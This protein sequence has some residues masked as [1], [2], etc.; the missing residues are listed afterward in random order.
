MAQLAAGRL[1][2]DREWSAVEEI[3]GGALGRLGE[4]LKDRPVNIQLPDT[5]PLLHVDAVL[6]QQVLVNLL[7]NAVEYSPEDSPIEISAT[8]A[9]NSVHLSVSD[10]GPGIPEQ[11]QDRV[12]EKFFRL[13]PE[14]T[15]RGVGFGHYSQMHNSL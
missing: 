7:D 13:R 3:V 8:L 6:I 5:T 10:R 12:F 2:L 14:S 4:S 1:P 9:R 11:V 15:S